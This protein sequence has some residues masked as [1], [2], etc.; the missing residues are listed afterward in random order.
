MGRS[1]GGPFA[2]ELWEAIPGTP[3]AAPPGG[4]IHHI[5]YWVDD[6]VQENAR[7]SALGFS[8]HA[9]VGRR[10]LLSAGPSGTVVELCDLRS[11][12]SIA[13]DLASRFS[14][15]TPTPIASRRPR[16]RS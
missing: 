10:P 11:D 8:P 2:V 13:R 16:V 3:L 6:T 15:A 5:G 1:Q 4:G 14:R 12:R 9:T 7:L